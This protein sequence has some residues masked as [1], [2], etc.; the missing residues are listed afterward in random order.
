[1]SED[2]ER[3]QLPA[4]SNAVRAPWMSSGAHAAPVE[5]MVVPQLADDEDS[6]EAQ[7]AGNRE[8]QNVASAAALVAAEEA[9]Q[10]APV[11]EEAPAW[12]P[13]PGLGHRAGRGSR[14]RGS[15]VG[16]ARLGR[17]RR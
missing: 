10:A 5:P 8:A 16:G 11:Q 12:E 2:Q 14:R 3:A 4:Q 15:R 13:T 6:W 1:M 7:E 17:S 9:A